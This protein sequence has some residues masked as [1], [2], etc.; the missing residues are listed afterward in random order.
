MKLRLA[1]EIGY[2][3]GVRNAVES[4]IEE[5]RKKNGPVVT[6]GE[7]IHNEH[8]VRVLRDQHGVDTPS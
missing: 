6:F 3:Y 7:I 5:A 1:K 4:A 2:C 8:A